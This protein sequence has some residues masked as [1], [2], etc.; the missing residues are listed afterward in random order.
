MKFSVKIW[1]FTVTVD[2]FDLDPG[3]RDIEF[4]I[5]ISW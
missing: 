1:H 3:D 5:R 2:L 4:S